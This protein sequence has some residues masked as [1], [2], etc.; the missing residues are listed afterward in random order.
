MPKDT[1]WPRRFKVSFGADQVRFNEKVLLD[2]MYIESKPVLH[3]V[4][5]GTRFS[6]AC[7]LQEVSTMAIWSAIVEC[8][9]NKYTGLP[10][11]MLTDQGSAFGD[12]FI[13]MAQL[14]QVDVQRTGIEAHSS[15][16]LG[17]RYHQPLR[18]T[19]RKIMKDVPSTTKTRA[20]SCAVKAMNDP[21]GPEGIVPSVLVFGE[22]PKVNTK[23]ET[24][25]KRPT[26]QER[27]TIAKIAR[28]E[29]ER[30]MEQLRVARALKHATPSGVNNLYNPGDKGLIWR[31]RI[32]NNRIGEWIGPFN[33]TSFDAAKRL[34]FVRDVPVGPSRLWYNDIHVFAFHVHVRH[35]DYETDP[36]P[37]VPRTLTPDPYG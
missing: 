27:A 11:R 6:A 34:V 35:H 22:Y 24:P 20:L 13:S 1:K 19:Y 12:L 15:L 3:M 37:R 31:E 9:V 4:D 26:L 33:V 28:D 2:I 36:N 30:P 32:V 16:S 17:E 21:L 5:E 29:M 18:N 7:F 8:W 14:D 23:S 10:N 25:S